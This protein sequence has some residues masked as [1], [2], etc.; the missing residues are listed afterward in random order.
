MAL[1]HELVLLLARLLARLPASDIMLLTDVVFHSRQQ[2]SPSEV[3]TEMNPQKH[4][5][6]AHSHADLFELQTRA[7]SLLQE[8]ITTCPCLAFLTECIGL[9]KDRF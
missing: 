1:K 8:R 7:S 5:E 9:C 2:L 4:F 3:L 6:K